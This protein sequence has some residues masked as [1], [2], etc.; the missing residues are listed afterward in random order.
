MIRTFLLTAAILLSCNAVFSQVR[1]HAHK[2]RSE[3]LKEFSDSLKNTPYP[4][5]LPA[6]GKKVQ[7]LG[8]D[9][10][11]PIGFMINYSRSVQD[12]AIDQLAVSFDEITYT[13]V[14]GI[15]NFPQVEPTV[16][17][18]TFRPD[19]FILPFWNVS[20]LFG[21]YT[22]NTH[23]IL[24]KPIDL[25]F[26]TKGG[27]TMA[28]VGTA[29]AG[30]VG[31]IF[32]NYS[33]NGTWTW[34][35]DGLRA[36]FASVN[37]IRVGHQHKNKHHPTRAWTAWLGAE[38]IHLRS[39]TL[40]K[41]DLEDALG[42]TPEDKERAAE[43]LDDWYNGLG[44]IDQALFEDFYNNLSGWLKYDDDTILY[45]DAEKS[46]KTPWAVIIGG[47]YQF[48]K[49]WWMTAEASWGDKRWRAV[50]SLAYRFGLKR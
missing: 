44:P 47:Q 34:S 6:F 49:H 16:D 19:V 50:F 3:E 35:K 39:Q 10:P 13:D 31:P 7:K 33:W 23:V 14:T 30:G 37:G 25:E 9:I 29:L 20:G 2:Y 26:D 15:V 17:V 40:G 5:Y 36:N 12:L 48:N 43:E 27:G 41:V 24:D 42:I 21:T 38:H 11:R 46:L 32:A 28:G 1:S 22:T 8:F 4:Y 45:Y 18:V